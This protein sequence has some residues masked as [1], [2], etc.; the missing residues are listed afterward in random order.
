MGSSKKKGGKTRKRG[1]NKSDF[2]SSKREVVKAEEGQAYAKV[3][4]MLGAGMLEAYC[5]KT[6][7]EKE[8]KKRICRIR[9]AMRKKVWINLHDFILVGLRDYQD[10]KADVIHKFSDDDVRQLKK[11]EEFNEA[12]LEENTEGGEQTQINFEK[13]EPEDQDVDDL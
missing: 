5:F 3:L 4:K 12:E 2:G 8:G 13:E 6:G 11:D 10:D 1:K 7:G 9:G